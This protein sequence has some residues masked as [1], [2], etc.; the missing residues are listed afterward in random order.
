[1]CWDSCRIEPRDWHTAL[2]SNPRPAATRCG[3]LLWPTKVKL[4]DGRPYGYHVGGT[5]GIGVDVAGLFYKTV[6]AAGL[7]PSFYYSLKDSFYLNAV[8]DTVQPTSTL[9]PGQMN[10]TQ[11]QFEDVSVAA[12]TELWSSYG[13][14]A[15]IWFDGGISDRIKSRYAG[16]ACSWDAY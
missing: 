10:V 12:V 2:W 15:E 5:G 4:P 7:A 1:M 6:K 3:F 8:H 11:E 9:L 16:W 14:L 13:P